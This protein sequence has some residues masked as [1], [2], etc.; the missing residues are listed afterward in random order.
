M[1]EGISVLPGDACG[2][3]TFKATSAKIYC[4]YTDCSPLIDEFW[5]VLCNTGLVGTA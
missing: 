5:T 2:I 4:F 3:S 1:I